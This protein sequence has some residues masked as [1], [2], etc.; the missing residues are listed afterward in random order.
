MTKRDQS[1]RVNDRVFV[2]IEG[3][4]LGTGIVVETRSGTNKSALVKFDDGKLLR[5]NQLWMTVIGHAKK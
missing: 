2:C 5:M 4:E 3:R 1:I